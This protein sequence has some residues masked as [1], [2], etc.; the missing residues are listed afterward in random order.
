MNFSPLFPGMVDT[1]GALFPAL[2]SLAIVVARRARTG[3]GLGDQ[4]FLVVVSVALSAVLSRVTIT[5]DETTLHFVP[6]ATLLLC[7]LVWCGH[8]ISPGFAFALTYATS[9]PVDVLLAKL[10]IGADFNPEFIGGGGWRDGLLILPALTALAV[11]YANW[12]M[13]HAG[14]ARLIG[15]GQRI[16]RAGRHRT[17]AQAAGCGQLIGARSPSP[18]GVVNGAAGRLVVAQYFAGFVA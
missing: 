5:P 18:A 4:L 14:G 1:M 9:L 3:L 2:I 11:M 12:R 10:L 15:F 7:Y 6:G 8:Y 16:M 13:L 17:S